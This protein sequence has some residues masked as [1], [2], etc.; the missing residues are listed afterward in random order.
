[1]TSRHKTHVVVGDGATAAAFAQHA[2]VAAGDRLI[3]VG[4]HVAQLGRGLAYQDHAPHAAWRYAY[5]L[6]SPNEVAHADFVPWFAAHWDRIAPDIERHQPRWLRFGAAH[7]AAQDW[8]A[9]FAPRAIFGD[10]IETQSEANLRRLADAGV[11]VVLRS[12]SVLQLS[13]G[14]AGFHL[15]L[16]TGEAL[17]ADSVDVA[18]GGAEPQR[19]SASDGPGVFETLYGAEARIAEAL[20]PGDT[21]TCIGGNAAMLDVLRLLQSLQD[22]NA[23]R[24]RVIRRGPSPE[25]LIARRPR[26]P[27]V[28][29]DLS[30]PFACADALLSEIDAACARFRAQGATMLELRRGFTAWFEDTDL[31]TLLPKKAEQRR[32]Q[33]HMERRFLRGTH[34]SIAD[35][36]RL[37]TNGQVE[38]VEGTVETVISSA[39][40]GADVTYTAAGQA[41]SLWSPIVINTAGPRD[42]LALDPLA[43]SML[44]QGLL[45]SNPEKTGV[46]VGDD[47]GCEVN[48]LR[49]LS[50]AVTEIGARVLALPLYNMSKLWDIV[51]AATPAKK[52]L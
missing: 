26:Q 5:L 31:N 37:H 2:P 50:P 43:R 19:F 28:R 15:R 32:A 29:P 6:N 23:I 39:P 35:F 34:D 51:A 10:W 21:V 46:M 42:P 14:A 44:E 41:H 38:V 16:D 11:D 25:P 49:Y 18:T 24:L 33:Q 52:T 47:L 27:G 48:G 40:R 9:L 1:M 45:R 3:I 7:I 30:G 13:H 36:E 20:V 4:P 8:G 17:A 12:A 22:E